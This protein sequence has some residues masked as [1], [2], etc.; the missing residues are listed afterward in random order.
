MPIPERG[1]KV[2]ICP[3][4]LQN[5][6]Q[7]GISLPCHPWFTFSESI[8]GSDILGK[9]C[10]SMLCSTSLLNLAVPRLKISDCLR[11][12]FESVQQQDRQIN[13]IN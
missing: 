9:K 7:V 4:I 8:A 10:F 12:L 6:F 3:G 11:L 5:E 1:I 13:I 2:T